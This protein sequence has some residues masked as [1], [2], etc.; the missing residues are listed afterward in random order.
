MV[1]D[2]TRN[3]MNKF[4]RGR[5]QGEYHLYKVPEPEALEIIGHEH[6][7]FYATR[8]RHPSLYSIQTIE[9]GKPP[10]ALQ[11]N[12]TSVT[13]AKTRIDGFLETEAKLQAQ[14]NE[15]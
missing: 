4:T 7:G 10:A 8:D 13:V 15:K 12:F 6:R 9:G 14:A 5:K 11:G 2:F 1:G 3:E